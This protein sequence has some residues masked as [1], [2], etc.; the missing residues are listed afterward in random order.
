M[1]TEN[2]KTLHAHPS[3]LTLRTALI[4]AANESPAT[5]PR[6]QVDANEQRA[7]LL[8]E[9]VK[10]EYKRPRLFLN[11]NDIPNQHGF[12]ENIQEMAG[13]HAR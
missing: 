8:I 3:L 5:P 6:T 4:A 2:K 11:W 7:I 12:R 9:K 10:A 13:A 1:L